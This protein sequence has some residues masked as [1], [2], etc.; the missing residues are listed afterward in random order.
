MRKFYTF[1]LVVCFGFVHSQEL[2]CTVTVNSDKLGQTNK[3]IFTTLE[4]SISEFVNK[5]NWTGDVYKQ[6]EKINCSMFITISSYS[7]DQFTG[8]IQVQSSRPVFNSTYSTPILNLNDKDFSFRYTEFENFNFNPTSFDSNLLSVIAFYSYVIIGSDA[9][10]FALNGGSKSLQTAQDISNT[11][12]QGG[13]KGWS[14]SDGDQNRYFLINDMLSNTF[15]SYREALYEYHFEGLDLMN[16]DQK[17]A[18]ENIKKSIETL[19]KIHFVRPNSYLMRVFFDAK[20]DEIVS[21]FTGG[22]NVDVKA[23][24]QTLNT[25]FL[26][27]S[28]KW[29][30]IR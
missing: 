6:N 4:K 9:D 17:L 20:S 16:K 26:M 30:N 8:T 23:L 7:S 27:N 15:S 13:Y 5:T 28:S 19:S 2:N 18:K 24:V 10:S 12:L 14:Q 3:Q 21:V 1:L 29:A 11:A 22:P 25:I